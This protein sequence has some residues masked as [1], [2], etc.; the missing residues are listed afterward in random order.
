MNFRHARPF[1]RAFALTLALVAAPPARA[2]S[3]EHDTG[4]VLFADTDDDDNDGVPDA[5]ATRLT[6]ATA[7]D[8][9]PLPP[10]T[11]VAPLALPIARFITGAKPWNGIGKPRGA[12]ALQGLRA[13]TTTAVIDGA[14]LELSVIEVL[15]IDGRGARVDLA[16]SH[17]AVSRRLP[18][19]AESE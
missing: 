1:W 18:S 9:V 11:D 13:G 19:A 2:G 7:T 14:A 10:H 17:A 3:G 8:L 16:R 4:L 12:L 15:L 6:G 5:E